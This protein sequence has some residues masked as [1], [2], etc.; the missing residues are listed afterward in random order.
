MI[1][2]TAIDY[3]N[4]KNNKQIADLLLNGPIQ[5]NS[6]LFEQNKA[7]HRKIFLDIRKGSQF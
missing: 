2:K 4:E 3:A 5:E 7:L 1:C 6:Y